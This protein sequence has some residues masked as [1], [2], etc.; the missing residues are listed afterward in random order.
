VGDFI[1]DVFVGMMC[2]DVD[3]RNIDY[4]VKK[5]KEFII[6]HLTKHFFS[7]CAQPNGLEL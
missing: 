2:D 4:T 5:T 1:Y 7:K 6:A 3:S